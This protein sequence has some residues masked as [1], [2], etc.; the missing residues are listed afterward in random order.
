MTD[1]EPIHPDQA[2][3]SEASSSGL[4]SQEAAQRLKQYGPNAVAEEKRHPL[5]NFLKNFGPRC[6]GCWRSRSF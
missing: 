2:T 1:A 5:L 6:P 3:H 4:S